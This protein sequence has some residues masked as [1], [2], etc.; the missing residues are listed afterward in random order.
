VLGRQ[1]EQQEQVREV[2]GKRRMH[3]QSKRY[4]E[5]KFT[6]N[7]RHRVWSCRSSR[8]ERRMKFVIVNR[9]MKQVM[10]GN[11]RRLVR[12]GLVLEPV[13]GRKCTERYDIL[14]RREVAAREK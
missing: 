3:E 6:K 12:D 10:F 13:H 8:E 5:S 9:R 7:Q 1:G 4:E 2:T 14:R 11:K